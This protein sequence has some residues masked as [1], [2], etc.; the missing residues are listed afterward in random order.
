MPFFWE[1]VEVGGDDMRM[2]ISVP[3]GSGPFPAVVVVYEASGTD[4]PARDFA[5]RLAA[6]GYAAV[7]PEIFHRMEDR[8]SAD[9]STR[10]ASLSD[11]QIEDDINATV[12]FLRNHP[13]IN[14][15][16]LGIT[17]FCMGGRIVWLMAA[18][19]S[20]FKAAA[21]F[22]PGN[23]MEAWGTATRTPFDRAGEISCPIM[24]HF[25]Q[26]DPNPSPADMAKL[27]TEL[28]RLGKAHQFFSYPNASHGF[29]GPGEAR[30]RK[31]AAETSW[32]RTIEF[33]ATHL[34]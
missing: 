30:Y 6:E 18:A 31:A 28:T 2:Y 17:G 33:F 26:E 21:P 4:E 29:M 15:E 34:K 22:Y 12:D 25:G 1:N 27:D 3:S 9:G 8:A 20:H 23:T 11:P 5:D 16:K 32:S 14:G 10:R 13:S 7:V 19:N 24:G